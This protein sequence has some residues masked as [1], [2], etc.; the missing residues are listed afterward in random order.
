MNL[1]VN[2]NYCLL[3]KKKLL[4]MKKETK[5]EK[6]FSIILNAGKEIKNATLPLRWFFS[7][8]LANKKPTH[9]VLV[10][11]TEKDL[12]SYS[13][14]YKGRRY[15][16]S[17]DQALAFL[18]TRK[19]DKHTLLAL[20]FDSREIA[21]T[22][23]ERNQYSY[24]IDIDVETILNEKNWSGSIATTFVEFEI[25]EECFAKPPQSKA[26]KIWWKFLFWPNKAKAIDECQIRKIS[27]FYALPKL[28]LFIIAQFFMLLMGSI[29][30]I[31]IVV[32][33]PIFWFFGYSL[34]P[35]SKIKEGMSES[36]SPYFKNISYDAYIICGNCLDIYKD[37]KYI[38]ERKFS[39]AYLFS[40][41]FLILFFIL[42]IFIIS[43]D[44][45]FGNE[46]LNAVTMLISLT[47]VPLLLSY[48]VSSGKFFK[49]NKISFIISCLLTTIPILFIT[50]LN[51]TDLKSIKSSFSFGGFVII[52]ISFFVLLNIISKKIKG[53]KEK[54]SEEDIKIEE[55]KRESLK[56]E[57]EKKYG[58][59]L[60]ESFTD[61]EKKEIPKETF[62][63]SKI[64]RDFK[65][66]FWKT[67]SN[68]CRPFE[69]D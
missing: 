62:F 9:I 34:A 13:T 2:L 67:K 4:F 15:L 59:Y 38:G 39:P 69:E 30:S 55:Q 7:K 52:F 51:F 60:K 11:L 28:L 57:E 12:N 31:R 17:V 33:R 66:F 21:V 37:G 27:W 32:A 53:N 20:A 18:Q 19:S 8:K 44:K 35:L 26:G 49:F 22:F 3:T 46:I 68:V 56:I 58:M 41:V 64:V 10:D 24:N 50:F 6:D 47:S 25:P 42:G 61:L 23:L 54:K 1:I 16:Y 5:K 48:F 43:S 63:T 36:F 14:N 29:N 65:I 45:I 40:F